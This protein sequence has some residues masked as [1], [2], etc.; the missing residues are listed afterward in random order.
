ML[1]SIR[2]VLF[3]LLIPTVF[4]I[5]S[6]PDGVFS[7]PA[8]SSPATSTIPTQTSL[9]RKTKKLYFSAPSNNISITDI[10]AM[11]SLL[12]KSHT[13]FKQYQLS[14]ASATARIAIRFIQND[15]V[16]QKGLT[17]IAMNPTNST[18]QT[19]EVTAATT[20]TTKSFKRKNKKM[21]KILKKL[22]QMIDSVEKT[23][24]KA[25]FRYN[26]TVGLNC[27][28]NPNNTTCY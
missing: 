5:R 28:L 24:N 9:T 17:T 8:T 1:H 18:K 16:W 13:Y 2:W 12:Q 7:L 15:S 6:R 22:Y 14:E 20:T 23:L 21:H 26:T 19:W 3:F 4:T 10:K 27:S 11:R 25:I